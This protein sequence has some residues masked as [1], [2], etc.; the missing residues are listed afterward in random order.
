MKFSWAIPNTLDFLADSEIPWWPVVTFPLDL[1]LTADLG[2]GGGGPLFQASLF[3]IFDL[4]QV[5]FHKELY[6]RDMSGISAILAFGP[7]I[8]AHHAQAFSNKGTLC[9]V[10]EREWAAFFACSVWPGQRWS[11][12]SKL[13]SGS[14]SQRACG[15]LA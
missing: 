1:K 11:S 12:C 2:Q 6:F 4:I 14:Q 3:R 7:I 15:C 10:P 13:L 5:N 9:P 8:S